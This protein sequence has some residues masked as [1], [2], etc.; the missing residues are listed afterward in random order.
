M[1][2][3]ET[4]QRISAKFSQKGIEL[5]QKKVEGKLKRLVEEFG[6]ALAEAERSVTN[7][8]A[9]EHNLT[10]PGKSGGKGAPVEPTSICRLEIEQWATIIGKVISVSKPNTPS[11]AQSG[12]IADESGAIGFVVWAKANAPLM[13]AD[14]WYQID[15]AI[16]D[17]YKGVLGLKIHSGSDIKEI[18]SDQS[19]APETVLVAN[20]APGVA[21]V[22][23]KCTSEWEATHERMLQ[24]GMVGDESGSVK[25]V[26]WKGDGAQK[27]TVGKVYNIYYTQ[28]A[29]Y[30]GKLSLNLNSGTILADEGD[31][32]VKSSTDEVIGAFV[33]LAPGSGLIKRCPVEGCNRT[34][35]RQNFC[36]IHEIQPKFVYDLR[37]KGWLDDGTKTYN[38]LMKRA[39]VEALTGMSLDEAIRIAENNPLGMDEVFLRMREK[40]LGRYFSCTGR[41]FDERFLVDTCVRKPFTSSEHVALLNSIGG[42]S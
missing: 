24:S 29:E 27:L 14:K 9:K 2:Y 38:L 17:E 26:T 31:I 35:S 12:V 37:I 23:V 16:V 40:I 36:P 41:N 13:Q 33:H 19:I 3:S 21:S 30:N 18:E 28:V 15:S 11:I 34:I 20:L 42:S 4:T 25:F 8:I 5:D 1:D 6:V 22:R 32:E 39:T 7:E 10:L